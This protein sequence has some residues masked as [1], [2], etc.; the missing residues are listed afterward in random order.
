MGK[1]TV[2]VMIHID[3]TLSEES[4][5]RIAE[6]VREDACVVSAD[7]PGKNAHM[8]RVAYNPLCTAATDILARVRNTGVHAELVGM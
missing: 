5:K 3:E 6:T 8:M 4:L 7:M 1:P 2:D